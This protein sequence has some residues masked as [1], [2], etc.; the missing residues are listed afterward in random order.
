M[1]FWFTRRS[2]GNLRC[3]YSVP[4]KG[5]FLRH[6]SGPPDCPGK[7]SI[8]WF[9]LACM[10]ACM[11]YPGLSLGWE[12]LVELVWRLWDSGRQNQRCLRITFTWSLRRLTWRF[13]TSRFVADIWVYA[14]RWFITGYLITQSE[15]FFQWWWCLLNHVISSCCSCQLWVACAR[16]AICYLGRM[17][18][19]HSWKQPIQRFDWLVHLNL[20]VL[21]IIGTG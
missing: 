21:P 15:F 1:L 4:N 2:A 10:H 3:H 12:L 7:G 6:L 8:G 18:L 17:A 20:Y 19:S 14:P 11:Q 13:I 16:G 9:E 5:C